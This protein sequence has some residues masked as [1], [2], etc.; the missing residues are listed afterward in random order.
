MRLVVAGGGTGGH[1]TPALAIAE[2]VAAA[3]P[4]IE[5]VMVGA[6]RGI[7]ARILPR[8][9][10]RFHLL[11]AE[12]L[13]RHHPWRNLR[14]PWIV[15]RLLG[16]V[17][18][19]LAEERPALV[20]GTGGYAAGPVVWR[21]TRLGIPA[22]IHEAN[23]FPGLATRW[24]ARRVRHVYLGY[25]E[26][27]AWIRAGPG[28]RVVVTGNPVRAPRA[29]ARGAA[30]SALGLAPE[31]ATLLVVGGSQ[32]SAAVNR[33]VACVLDAAGFAA[34][35]VIWC[36]GHAHHAALARYAVTG[37]VLVTPF[38][39]PLDD[40][41]AA[42]DLAVARSGAMTT[43]ELAAW[44]VPAVF[45]PLPGAA[46]DHQLHNA[47]AVANAGGA[48]VL[49]EAHLA[50]RSLQTLVDDLL[51]DPARLAAMAAVQ[52]DR[53]RPEATAEIVSNI[54]TLLS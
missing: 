9:A 46:R 19:V 40:A 44:G 14:W 39:D 36:T 34:L 47:R 42:A 41:Y 5:V 52:R 28:T 30:R 25:P 7:E 22:A 48:V 29:R 12:P 31:R 13:Y 27:Q 45:V 38:L 2:A 10:F 20:V 35:N 11:P 24:L 54:L 50:S 43:A 23:A 16:A 37:R 17:R 18:R 8:K 6:R 49:P 53:A 26:A 1:L 51:A 3:R 32:G 33:A 4:E 15:F 21:A